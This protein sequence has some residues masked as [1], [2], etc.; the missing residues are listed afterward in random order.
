MET[1]TAFPL[2]TSFSLEHTDEIEPKCK[3]QILIQEL[4]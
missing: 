1:W 3:P 2:L 4:Y